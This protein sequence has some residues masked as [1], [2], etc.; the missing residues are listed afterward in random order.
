MDVP[1][2]HDKV[3]ILSTHRGCGSLHKIKPL[4]LPAWAGTHTEC[5]L[6]QR[7]CLRSMAASGGKGFVIFRDRRLDASVDGPALMHICVALIGLGGG[8]NNK[9]TKLGRHG[10]G[11]W[12]DLEWR[13]GGR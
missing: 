1:F 2:G 8:G 7:G 13:S 4:K 10:G 6:L 5:P 9:D 12:E 3:T 11:I